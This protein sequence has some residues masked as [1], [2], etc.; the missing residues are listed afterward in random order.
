G[1]NFGAAEIVDRGVPVRMK[2]LPR[3]LVL[4]E[5]GAVEMAKAVRIGREVRRHPVEDNADAYL[6]AAVDE[7]S[8]TFRFAEAGGRR[9]EAGRLVAP[10]WVEGKFRDRQEFDMGKAHI[11]AIGDQ[12]ACQLVPGEEVASAV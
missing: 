6:V 1:H 7:A 10:G 12:A 8:K 9:I 5:R 11:D 3:I 2:T 4:V